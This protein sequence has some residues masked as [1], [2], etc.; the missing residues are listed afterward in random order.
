[1]SS[2]AMQRDGGEAM[3][4]FCIL[5]LRGQTFSPSSLL[6]GSIG[7][8]Y[9]MTSDLVLQVHIFGVSEIHR[10]VFWTALHST[11]L[12]CARRLL[13]SACSATTQHSTARCINTIPYHSLERKEH[14][15]PCHNSSL[16]C[17]HA[18]YSP[19]SSICNQLDEA[20]C[21]HLASRASKSNHAR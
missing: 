12:T 19:S 16:R 4:C 11:P 14:A 1:M 15:M 8:R 3:Q 13:H 18:R 17:D 6:L 9:S 10:R 7:D 2:T 20:E 21:L 5:H